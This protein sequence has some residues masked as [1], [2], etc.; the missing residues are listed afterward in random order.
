MGNV[1]RTTSKANNNSNN[2]SFK[3]LTENSAFAKTLLGKW[4]PFIRFQVVTTIKSSILFF[5]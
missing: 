5:P 3:I 2:N 4:S 1:L